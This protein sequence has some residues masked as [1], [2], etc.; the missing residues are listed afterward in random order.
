[1]LEKSAQKVPEK[2]FSMWASSLAE[3]LSL[4]TGG[5]GG[6]GGGGTVALHQ[7]SC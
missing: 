3:Q 6:G 5:G 2:I 1:M 4:S 7:G